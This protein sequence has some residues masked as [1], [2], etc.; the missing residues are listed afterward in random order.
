MMIA[1]PFELKQGGFGMALRRPVYLR[2]GDTSSFWG[3][4]IVVTKVDDLLSYAHFGRVNGGENN[5]RL[6]VDMNGAEM[7]VR[8][9]APADPAVQVSREFGQKTWHVYVTPMISWQAM[10]TFF[11]FSLMLVLASLFA[12]IF[13][14]RLHSYADSSKKDALT[15]I[16][17][18]RGFD[19]ALQG[20]HD[21]QKT[22]QMLLV[23]ID[24]NSFKT[25][26][27]VYGHAVGDILLQSFAEELVQ[28][29]GSHGDVGRNGGDEFHTILQNPDSA[30]LQRLADFFNSS[31]YI[32]NG[33]GRISYKVSG[34]YTTYPDQATS[35]V[36]LYREADVALYRAKTAKGNRF[37]KYSEDMREEPREQMGFN[38]RD[39]A[40]GVPGP[41]LIYRAD[42]T[43]KILFANPACVRLLGCDS[44]EEFMELTKGSFKFLIYPD[45]L[46]WAE[47]SI[48]LQ[49]GDGD[50]DDMDYLIYRV[51]TKDGTVKHISNV[52]KKIHH[53]YYGDVYF[54]L[55]VD[56]E[57][58]GKFA[59]NPADPTL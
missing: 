34:G 29:V 54:V 37:W 11:G 3:F 59:T 5:Y 19:E 45:D 27:D 9:N 38:F 22:R 20:I 2:E 52:G 15:G 40:E 30:M 46:D 10:L 43:K 8:G 28:L 13:S 6:T 32:T 23:A 55:L 24:I 35:V 14:V 50:G 44:P 41:V 58:S 7:L 31:H 26:N 4:S 12:A 53:D 25:F 18:R 48:E 57:S 47:R 17:N 36:D 51:L 39:L 1:G 49:Q 42:E 16:N 56:N 33:D 21:D